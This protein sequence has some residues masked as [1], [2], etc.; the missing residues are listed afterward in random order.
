MDRQLTTKENPD[1]AKYYC[2]YDPVEV[3]ITR[4]SY[5]NKFN[6]LL[7]VRYWYIYCLF[8]NRV[9]LN[10]Y[11]LKLVSRLSPGYLSR[12]Y[13]Y[14]LFLQIDLLTSCNIRWWSSILTSFHAFTALDLMLF[15]PYKTVFVLKLTSWFS[16]SALV[17]PGVWTKVILSS[18]R[19]V[20]RFPLMQSWANKQFW[21][22]M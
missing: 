20:G 10:D 6:S 22:T 14:I 15:E 7:T 5:I 18:K 13:S 12:R 16:L 1:F 21:C 11:W 3:L 2:I 9:N 17:F 8:S 19:G 4:Y